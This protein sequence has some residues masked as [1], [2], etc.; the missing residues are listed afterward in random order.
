MPDG[1]RAAIDADPTDFTTSAVYADWL[2]EHDRPEEANFMRQ[3]QSL[4]AD[5]V[6][7]MTE[8]SETEMPVDENGDDY[9]PLMVYKKLIE[10]ELI[11]LGRHAMQA[12]VRDSQFNLNIHCGANERF[13][14]K[15][16]VHRER[17][18]ECWSII[19][20]IYVPQE[21]AENSS[22]SCSC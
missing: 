3:R 4:Y 21:T 10:L 7:W 17:F 9:Y 12:Y 1:F 20:G 6:K 2:D 15:L 13:R 8:F 5:A 16:R 18:W 11:E 19:T 22:F 14:D